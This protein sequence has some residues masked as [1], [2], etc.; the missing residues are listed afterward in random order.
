[1]TRIIAFLSSAWQ[2]ISMT[3]G[4]SIDITGCVEA[5]FSSSVPGPRA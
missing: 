2:I 4:Q 1:V 5:G 3:D